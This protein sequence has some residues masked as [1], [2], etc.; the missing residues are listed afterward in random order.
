M[1]KQFEEYLQSKNYRPTTS[2]DYPARLERLCRKESFSLEQLV[3]HI[4]EILPLYERSGKRESYGRRS[5]TSVRQAL[6]RFNAFLIES[7]K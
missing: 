2:I 4:K 6:R 3:K 7:S 1:Q 5:H